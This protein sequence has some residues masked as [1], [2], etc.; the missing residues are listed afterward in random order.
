MNWKLF[1]LVSLLSWLVVAFPVPGAE[2]ALLV[3]Q[4]AKEITA[5][6]ATS[7]G[8][9][10]A[11]V[12]PE[13][14][15][16]WESAPPV[17]TPV[18][19]GGRSAVGSTLVGHWTDTGV[20]VLRP[21]PGDVAQGG[22]KAFRVTDL[23]V[24]DAHAWLTGP[25]EIAKKPIGR[26]FL[27]RVDAAGHAHVDVDLGP[28]AV[29]VAGAQGV[30]Y[31]ARNPEPGRPHPVAALERPGHWRRP[32]ETMGRNAFFSWTP[33]R[34]LVATAA[35]LWAVA[36]FQGGVEVD[37]DVVHSPGLAD[38]PLVGHLPPPVMEQLRQVMRK[39]PMPPLPAVLLLHLDPGGRVRWLT[40]VVPDAL[41][42]GGSAGPGVDPARIDGFPLLA[43][44]ADDDV[45]VFGRYV[46]AVRTGERH[47]ASGDAAGGSD[48]HCFLASW[49]AQGGVRWLRD[50]P[51]CEGEPIGLSIT[52][53]RLVAVTGH[54][55]RVYDLQQGALIMHQPL[56][57]IRKAHGVPVMHWTQA[58]V[59]DGWLVLGGVFRGDA[60][61]LGHRLRADHTSVV[62][63]RIA[64]V[65]KGAGDGGNGPGRDGTGK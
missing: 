56:P 50:V 39:T 40:T 25:L 28:A 14:W 18:R 23:A 22:E 24:E 46:H 60:E 45:Y 11:V 53:G 5:L 26:F 52:R 21:L 48:A 47:L 49:D 58:S 51:R 29:D 42:L 12:P 3:V 57:R 62:L 17:W 10:F 27:A 13:A 34:G 7:R 38:L 59:H 16:P 15:Q 33:G 41:Q 37:G 54:Q 61:L 63:A 44:D 19:A 32:L 65:M 9:W 20:D 6:E 1:R 64:L 2:T 4:G 36:R 31:V 35:G 8:A 43:V 30:R 55:V